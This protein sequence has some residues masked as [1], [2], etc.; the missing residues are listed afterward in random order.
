[1]CGTVNIVFTYPTLIEGAQLVFEA[2]DI[3]PKKDSEDK[4][5]VNKRISTTASDNK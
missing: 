5:M 1:L 2:S 4:K 3:E